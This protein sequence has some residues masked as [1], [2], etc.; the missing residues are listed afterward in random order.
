MDNREKIK[1]STFGSYEDVRISNACEHDWITRNGLIFGNRKVDWQCSKCK[2]FKAGFYPKKPYTIED[3]KKIKK[4]KESRE[5]VKL[6]KMISLLPIAFFTCNYIVL[7]M[8]FGHFRLINGYKYMLFEM[9]EKIESSWHGRLWKGW[10]G[11]GFPW[12]AVVRYN[13]TK[14]RNHEFDHCDKWSKYGAWFLVMYVYYLIRYGY[15]NNPLE[16]EAREAENNDN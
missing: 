5:E 8:F 13:C 6:I 7:G 16:V 10:A 12:Q 15:K 3:I 2:T 14:Y 1:V 4:E 9:T 11:I